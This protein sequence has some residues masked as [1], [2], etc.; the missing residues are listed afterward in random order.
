[1]ALLKLL[2]STLINSVHC[3]YLNVIFMFSHLQ[4][5]SKKE[6]FIFIVVILF[7]GSMCSFPVWL[8]D[9][10]VFDSDSTRQRSFSH[11]EDNSHILY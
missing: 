5:G 10:D 9:W 2:L 3:H 4:S 6:L 7:S 1:M 8:C 11:A